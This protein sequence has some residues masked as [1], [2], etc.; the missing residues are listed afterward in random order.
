MS[1]QQNLDRGYIHSTCESL[2]ER[3]TKS[4]ETST[5]SKSSSTAKDPGKDKGEQMFQN[6]WTS[7][8]ALKSNIFVSQCLNF[9]TN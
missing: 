8:A 4:G 3:D 7:I 9:W 6:L 1:R 2:K 5:E